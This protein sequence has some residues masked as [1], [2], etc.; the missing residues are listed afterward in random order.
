LDASGYLK[1]SG[2]KAADFEDAGAA[3]ALQARIHAWLSGLLPRRPPLRLEQATKP[4]AAQIAGRGLVIWKDTGDNKEYL[5]WSNGT[6]TFAVEG[7]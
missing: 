5:V 1:D 4:T 7:T 2:S 6:A 3:A